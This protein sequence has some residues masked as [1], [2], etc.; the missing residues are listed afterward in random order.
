MLKRSHP[1]SY[2]RL[3]APTR[4]VDPV[5]TLSLMTA[6]GAKRSFISSRRAFHSITSSAWP[7]S[8]RA[9]MRPSVIRDI[10][11]YNELDGL[12][13]RSSQLIFWIFNQA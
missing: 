1:I 11:I 13:S 10:V 3:V 8:V 6:F 7:S 5:A 4:R 12:R 2:L 9:T